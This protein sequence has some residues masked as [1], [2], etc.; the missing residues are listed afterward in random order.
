[1]TL[2]LGLF[3]TAAGIYLLV[4]HNS[5]AEGTIQWIEQAS[6][7]VLLGGTPRRLSP[8]EAR[9]IRL[10]T[11]AAGIFSL[12]LGLVSIASYAFRK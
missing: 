5:E 8:W 10:L 1:M 9:S 11:I 3:Y 2:W 6:L 7:R 12:I 4:C